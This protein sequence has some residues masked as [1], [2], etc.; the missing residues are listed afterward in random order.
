M[1]NK[2]TVWAA[3]G[4]LAMAACGVE[5]PEDEAPVLE[6]VQRELTAPAYSTLLALPGTMEGSPLIASNNP[7]SVSR[8]GLLLATTQLTPVDPNTVKRTLNNTNFDSTCPAG[9]LKQFV[10]YMHHLNQLGAGARYYVFLEPATSG[11]S[12]SFN[13]YGAAIS[14]LDTGTSTGSAD[15][16]D[17][18]K[19]P[20]YNVSLAQL[21]GTLP[22]G[23]RTAYG[24]KFINL[25]SSTLPYAQTISSRYTLVNLAANAGSS[26]DA[27]VRVNANGCLRLRV[28]AAT[29]NNAS[30]A[31]ADALGKKQFAWGNVPTTSTVPGGA[32]CTD[33]QSIGWG[34][35][36]G[37]YQYERWAGSTSVSLTSANSVRGWKWLA[38]PVNTQLA[39]GQCVPA[40]SDVSPSSNAQRA[41][42][43]GYYSTNTSGQ[44]EL[45]DSDAYSTGNYGAEYLLGYGVTNSTGQCVVASLQVSSY[46]GTNTCASTTVAKTRH[47]DGAAQVTENGTKL[48]PVR[49]FTKCPTGPHFTT[50]A[51]KQLTAGQTV[52]WNVKMF[53]PGLI[54]IPQGVLLTSCPCGQTC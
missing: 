26:V 46:P 15:S 54:S 8:E 50:I 25:T 40:T 37:I 48:S 20:S 18:G 27:R 11:T 33:S 53:I 42:A 5:L 38:A 14:Q 29:A 41:P 39:D 10:F 16:L 34:R 1:W 43:L 2:Q 51:S 44:T 13:A 22:V 6:Q 49:L 45:R 36:A 17:P 32:P 21:T 52:N 4:A 12:V 19:S 3:C 7:E 23:V 31:L 28:V 9:S 35:P 47:Y 24:S 30:E